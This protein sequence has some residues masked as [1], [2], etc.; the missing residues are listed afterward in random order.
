MTSMGVY[1]CPFPW[2]GFEGD[3]I[4]IRDHVPECGVGEGT[5]SYGGY[6]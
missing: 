3:E 6:Q 5:A 1:G 4:E 2:C